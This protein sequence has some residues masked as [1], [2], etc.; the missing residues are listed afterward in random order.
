MNQA[1]LGRQVAKPG[2]NEA[3]PCGSGRKFKACC[4]L[5]AAPHAAPVPPNLALR[6]RDATAR[7][8]RAQVQGRIGDAIH[9]FQEAASL[10]TGNGT[11]ALELGRSLVAIGRAAEALPW[12]ERATQQ[13]P[14]SSPAQVQKGLALE[15]LGWHAEAAEA[16]RNAIKLTPRL[17]EAHSRLGIVLF[18]QDRRADAAVSFR[19]GAA[20]APGE[21]IGRL[22]AAYALLAEGATGDARFALE[23][24]VKAEPGNTAARAEL[25]KLLAEAGKADAAW[26]QFENLLRLNPRAVAHYYDLVR[27]RRIAEADRP[28]VDQMVAASQRKD[29]PILQRVFLELALGKARDDLGDPEKAMHH[30][31]VAGKLKAGIRPLDRELIRRRVDWQINQFSREIVADSVAV[32]SSDRTPILI[33]GM[34][35]S[36]TTLVESILSS[37]SQVA[38]GQELPFWN[39][40]G[41]EV[42]EEGTIPVWDSVQKLASAY[43]TVLR[44]ISQAPQVTDKKPDNFMWAGLVHRV[45]PRA[46]FVHCRRAPLD[47]CVSV[48]GNF[49]APRPDF[50]TE[51][52]D[53]VFYYQEYERI[54]AHWRAVL[55]ADCFLELDYE[56]LVTTPEPSI[57]RLL[58]FCGL[59][60]ESACLQPE[61]CD[62]TVNTA[63]LWQ[64]RQPIFRGSIGR[65]RRYQ[66]SL[67]ALGALL[68][69]DPER[70]TSSDLR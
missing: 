32:G 66:S 7:A 12:L 19:R 62:R 45:F 61:R 6:I 33:I 29:L 37:H 28:L 63:S 20:L 34:P 48:M 47:T 9:A 50:S 13:L 21:P 58:D 1:P 57:R 56:E 27:I 43:L 67:G 25:G 41:R 64:V 53:L 60:W 11:F 23:Q 18:V 15:Q 68:G 44:G 59:D 69:N 24:I 38:A 17:A 51:P 26:M 10:D 22:S 14:R 35:R 42:M 54:M 52:G 36:G 3:C 8:A 39:Q 30:F 31:A 55:P 5:K 2:R 46:R 40:R 49:F 16:Y 70:S 65:W 4:A